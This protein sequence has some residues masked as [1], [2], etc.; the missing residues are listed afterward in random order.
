[1]TP[2][3]L[4]PT[5]PARL[6]RLSN[7]KLSFAAFD[8]RTATATTDA[9]DIR[10]L[11]FQERLYRPKRVVIETTP[12]GECFWRFVP[13]ARWQEGVQNEGTFPRVV[14]ICG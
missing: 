13:K 4:D 6:F 10:N 11:S 2:G 1:M 14:D 8:P 5:Q 12:T 9:S 7:S 3:V